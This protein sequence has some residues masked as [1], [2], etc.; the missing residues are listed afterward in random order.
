VYKKYKWIELLLSEHESVSNIIFIQEPLWGHIRNVASMSDK[1]G[2][3]IMG[4]PK[5][6]AWR[7]FFPKPADPNLDSDQ[8]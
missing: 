6:L 4:M 7:Q 3:P 8:S 1:V 2:D 5:H